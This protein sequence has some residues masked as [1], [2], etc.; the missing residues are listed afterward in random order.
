MCKVSLSYVLL[1][2]GY[3]LYRVIIACGN[4]TNMQGCHGCCSCGLYVCAKCHG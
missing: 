3:G 4:L 1:Q 2:H